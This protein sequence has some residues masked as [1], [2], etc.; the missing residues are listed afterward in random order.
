MEPV[1]RVSSKGFQPLLKRKQ[2]NIFIRMDRSTE[3]LQYIAE[4]LVD[5]PAFVRVERKTDEMGVLLTLTV[6]DDDMG[7]ILGKKGANAL[8]LRTLIRAI[9]ARDKEAVHLRIHDPNPDHGKEPQEA[10]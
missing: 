1:R 2:K 5:D 9:G 7:K 10:R 4:L 3:F 6:A 8:A